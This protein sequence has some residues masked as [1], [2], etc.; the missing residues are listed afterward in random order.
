MSSEPGGLLMGDLPINACLEKLETASVG[1][2]GVSM[3]A[4]PVV[5]PVNFA[6]DG[7][8]IVIRTTPGTKLSAAINQ[9]VVAFEVDDYDAETA[10]GWSVL[11]QGTAREITTTWGLERA[12][13]LPLR[14]VTPDGA[15]DRF[16]EVEMEI[17]T[18][19]HIE[20]APDGEVS[21]RA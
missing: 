10:R 12:R 21:P 2:L 7:N 3:D 15:S 4:L 17:V 9:A 14:P 13:S 20:P 6:L 8:S 16:V 5:L 1:R 19:R 18:G 11:V